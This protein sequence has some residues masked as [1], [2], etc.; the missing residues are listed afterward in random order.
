[1]PSNKCVMQHN[2]LCGLAR[3]LVCEELP[4][5]AILPNGECQ[6][7]TEPEKHV[8]L[9]EHAQELKR[10]FLIHVAEAALKFELNPE[11]D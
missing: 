1:M 7:L 3:L 4:C 8:Q 11:K 9:K 2:K 10:K 6:M 5:K